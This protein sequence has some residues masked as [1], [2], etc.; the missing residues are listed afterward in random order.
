[1]RLAGRVDDFR[2]TLRSGEDFLAHLDD[3]TP[4]AHHGLA[5]AVLAANVVLAFV[6]HAQK[7]P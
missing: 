2:S 4:A 7:R 6:A 3:A 1:M 5:L